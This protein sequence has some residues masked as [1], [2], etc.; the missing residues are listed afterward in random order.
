MGPQAK[1]EGEK[2]VSKV[3]GEVEYR[4]V[5]ETSHDELLE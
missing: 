5:V 3:R 4:R 1:G 2:K